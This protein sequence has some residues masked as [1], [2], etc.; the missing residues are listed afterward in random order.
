MKTTGIIRRI[1]ELGRIVIPKEIRKSLRIHEGDTLEIFVENQIINL[2]KYSYLDS[3]VL[4][5]NKIV[6]VVSDYLKYNILVLDLQK[7]IACTKDLEKVYLNRSLSDEFIN[8]LLERKLVFQS[9]KCNISFIDNEQIECSYIINPLIIDS[10]VIGAIIL[11]DS[12]NLTEADVLISK[13]LS[14][15]LIKNIEE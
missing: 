13:L 15:F 11:F 6:S 4:T 8:M 2:K 14:S 3:L 7:V 1:D 5:S 12:Y 9:T 10:D